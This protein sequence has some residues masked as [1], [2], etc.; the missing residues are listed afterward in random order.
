MFFFFFGS[1]QIAWNFFVWF[2]KLLKNIQKVIFSSS[3]LDFEIPSTNFISY[4][5]NS[6]IL[7]FWSLNLLCFLILY[8]YI[9]LLNTL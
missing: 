9:D 4:F 1:N 7:K 8:I 5:K 2:L 3:N 6:D